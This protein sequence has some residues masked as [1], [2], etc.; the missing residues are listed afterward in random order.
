MVKFYAKKKPGM[1][2]AK[3]GK[4]Y[5]PAKK[6]QKRR[7]KRRQQ[8]K[9]YRD[10]F[11]LQVKR[12]LTY[13]FRN[14][15]NPPATTTGGFSIAS[16]CFQLNSCYDP[17]VSSLAAIQTTSRVNHQPMGFD[18]LMQLYRRYLVSY[19]RVNC[20]FAFENAVTETTETEVTLPSGSTRTGQLISQTPVRVGYVTSDR[21]D[22]PESILHLSS[23]GSTL[24]TMEKLIEQAKSGQLNPKSAQFKYKTICKDQTARFSLAVNPWKFVKDK[25][26]ISYQDYKENNSCDK[27]HSPTDD[28][29][30]A[31]LFASPLTT[32]PG[33][34]HTPII[35]YG[36]IDFD[37]I[38]S[39][40]AQLGQS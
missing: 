34:N 37:V 7:N 21:D 25:D 16:Q 1:V 33:T 27:A 38:F 15:I 35:C 17:D 30:Y 5:Y 18:E 13:A 31:H 40:M 39:E 19:A 8:M 22:L 9:V 28:P 24:P 32:V 10:P 2:R 6:I 14:T 23:P 3:S 11:P 36:T 29:V 20:H 26:N 4:Y 12:R